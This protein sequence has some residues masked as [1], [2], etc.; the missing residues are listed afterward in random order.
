MLIFHFSCVECFLDKLGVSI[1]HTRTIWRQLQGLSAEGVELYVSE[2]CGS[3]LE[4][5]A[6]PGA[7]A[8]VDKGRVWAVEQLCGAVQLPAASTHVKQEALQFLATHAFFTVQ[9]KPKSK[10]ST[11]LSH[12]YVV[13]EHR[14]A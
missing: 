14:I 13:S 4:A 1:Y 10:V 5:A 8:A 12:V 2:L 6:A 11:D 7:D 3:F 9:A